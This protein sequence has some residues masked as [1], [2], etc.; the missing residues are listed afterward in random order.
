MRK[1]LLY[2]LLLSSFG[3]YLHAQKSGESR[4]YPVYDI[5]IGAGWISGARLGFRIQPSQVISI[6]ASIGYHV[7]N[8]I[9]LSDPEIKY[10]IGINLHRFFHPNFTLSLLGSYGDK[11]HLRPNDLYLIS[12]DIGYLSFDHSGLNLFARTGPFIGI[13]NNYAGKSS[14]AGFNFDLGIAWVFL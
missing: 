3:E 1:T 4:S 10:G 2:I 11:F 6:E 14:V 7:A 9:S 5:H 8:F 13:K 12:L